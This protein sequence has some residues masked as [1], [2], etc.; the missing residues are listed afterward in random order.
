[1]FVHYRT[2]GFVFKKTDRG[3]ADQIFTIYTKDFGKLVFLARAARKIQSK[4]RGG[5]PLFAVSEIEFIQ[6]KAY[7]TLTD[8]FVVERFGEIPRSLTKLKIAY[9]IGEVLGNLIKEEEENEGIWRLLRQTLREL[10]DYSLGGKRKAPISVYCLSVYYYF[11]WNLV[12]LAGFEPSLYQCVFCQR[13]ISSEPI[14]FDPS[15]GGIVC[16]N[17]FRK[18]ESGRKVDA[19]L[20]KI[21]RVI[22]ERKWDKF[23][24][25]KITPL[26]LQS[27]REISNRYYSHLLGDSR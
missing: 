18:S 14:Y 23:K 20:V 17:C 12:A 10:N 16:K 27:L 11:F 6:G 19:D 24:K 5:L 8:A 25:V 4:L 7:K 9:K 1:M 22:L 13:K 26:H 2:Q 21:L 3:E 15:Q